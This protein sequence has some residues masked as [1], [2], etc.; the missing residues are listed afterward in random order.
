MYNLMMRDNL[1][2]SIH[3]VEKMHVLGTPPELEFFV[4]H[5]TARF[6]QKPVALC[7]DHSGFHMKEVAKKLL[8]KN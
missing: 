7:C 5:V 4:E 1:K 3:Q 8:E 2:V 6:G